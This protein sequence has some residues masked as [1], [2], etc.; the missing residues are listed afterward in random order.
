MYVC[1]CEPIRPRIEIRVENVRLFTETG[2]RDA[3]AI[4]SP[5]ILRR[6][7][8]ILKSRRKLGLA[9][10]TNRWY[11]RLNFSDSFQSLLGRA[12]GSNAI[13]QLGCEVRCEAAHEVVVEP[14]K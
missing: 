11:L 1:H 8:R 9:H 4:A 2:F 12:K 6:K 5:R 3:S 14:A 10:L 13:N 7:N